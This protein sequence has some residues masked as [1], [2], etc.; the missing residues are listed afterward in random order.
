MQFAVNNVQRAVRGRQEASNYYC[1][2]V[3]VGSFSGCFAALTAVHLR[4]RCSLQL[5]CV[6]YDL[7]EQGSCFGS[8][9]NVL[10]S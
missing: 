1:S 4:C 6:S 2:P 8:K 10:K 9:I 7:V 5:F 3:E